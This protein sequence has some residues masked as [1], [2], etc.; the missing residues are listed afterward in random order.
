MILGGSQLMF[1]GL[2]GQYVARVF[3]ELK[4]RPMYILRQEPPLPL[5]T[6][7]EAETAPLADTPVIDPAAP[8]RSS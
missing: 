4:G 6:R 3:E 2:V 8:S 1:I 5:Y 7:P